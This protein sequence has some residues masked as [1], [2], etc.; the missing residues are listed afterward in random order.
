MG[1]TFKNNDYYR[2][3]ITIFRASNLEKEKLTLLYK[4]VGIKIID[5]NFNLCYLDKL[6]VDLQLMEETEKTGN[7]YAYCINDTKD[8]D[9]KLE[10]LLNYYQYVE[11]RSILYDIFKMGYYE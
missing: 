4:Y 5:N 8:I 11:L 3:V 6:A 9:I 1:R 10:D 2:L 7:P